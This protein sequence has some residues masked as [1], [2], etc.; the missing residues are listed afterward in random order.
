MLGTTKV[1]D[2]FILIERIGKSVTNT[3]SKAKYI[4][5]LPCYQF[6]CLKVVEILV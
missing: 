6:S 5:L 1:Y 3:K 4:L 2:R